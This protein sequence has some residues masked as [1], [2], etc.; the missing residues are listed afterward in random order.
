MVNKE[1]CVIVSNILS[2]GSLN[3]TFLVGMTNHITESVATCGDSLEKSGNIRPKINTK[4]SPF[5]VASGPVCPISMPYIYST[6]Y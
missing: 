3:N 2:T 6:N 1:I 5:P 4:M